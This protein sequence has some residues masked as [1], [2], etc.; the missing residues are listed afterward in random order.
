MRKTKKESPSVK[1]F[2]LG[3]LAPDFV[4]PVAP[5]PP[6]AVSV[7]DGELHLI[8]PLA[9]SANE[10]W[11]PLAKRVRGKWIGCIVT[12]AV[13]R[14]YALDVKSQL[15][16]LNVVPTRKP[17]EVRYTAYFKD[18]RR[19]LTNVGKVLYDV[20]EGLVFVNDRQI[21]A[22]GPNLHSLDRE[23]P[24]LEIWIRLLRAPEEILAEW[25]RADS[26]LPD[27]ED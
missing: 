20:L 14:Q 5:T 21:K 3:E 22:E 13:A 4:E 23:A 16:A 15:K 27:F 2:T 9:P 24:R 26:L 1:H 6:P 25:E 12:S 8:L 11:T 18:N 10:Y 19:D 17:V 7:E